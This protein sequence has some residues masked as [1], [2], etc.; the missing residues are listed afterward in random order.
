MLYFIFRFPRSNG[1]RVIL[2]NT[3]AGLKLSKWFVPGL[4]GIALWLSAV[5][6]PNASR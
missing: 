3:R 2:M 1:N 6:D 5:L 4:S